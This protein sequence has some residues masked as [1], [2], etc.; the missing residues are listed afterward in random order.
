M[1]R[2]DRIEDELNALLQ[3]LQRTF[4]SNS[5]PPVITGAM[6]DAWDAHGHQKSTAELRRH[7]ARA[8]LLMAAIAL[9]FSRGRCVSKGI[10]ELYPRGAPL[11]GGRRFPG[12]LPDNR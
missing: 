1:K 7:L 10:S 6:I 11:R 8:L 9:A 5:I 3:K 12:E 4:A 2:S